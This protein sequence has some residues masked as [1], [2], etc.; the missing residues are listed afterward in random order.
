MESHI[1][2]HFRNQLRQARA[3][4]LS[5]SEAFHEIIYAV[6]RLGLYLTGKSSNLEGYEKP[7]KNLA[8]ESPLAQKIPDRHRRSHVPFDILYKIVKT[9]RNDALHQGA[10]ARHLTDHA[11][12]LSLIIEDALMSSL[13]RVCDYMVRDLI[14]A[15]PWQPISFVRQQ[16]LAN[17]FTYLP[18]LCES[19]GKKIWHLLSDYS[20]AQYLRS[21]PYD[22]RNDR[23]A[24]SV[25]DAIQQYHL[26]I[27]KAPT[28]C[29]EKTIDEV[30]GSF[31]Q[32]KPMLV[33]DDSVYEN[34]LGI[35]T[36]FDLL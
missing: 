19:S 14:Y 26:K 16:M 29:P 23:L 2:L 24:I 6:E 33:I 3:S 36:P 5:D 15:Y 17:S 31:E 34:L 1:A 11:V 13:T 12:Q 21:V 4:A 28:C 35:L 7:L 32:G 8:A 25:S 30:I 10:F 20:V 27:E 9:G 18:M 22:Q